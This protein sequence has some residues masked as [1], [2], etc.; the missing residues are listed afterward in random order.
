M[1]KARQKSS[2]HFRID[3]F[4][5]SSI[6]TPQKEFSPLHLRDGGLG[7]RLVVLFPFDMR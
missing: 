5:T 1:I 4:D 7:R 3:L 6:S 2:A